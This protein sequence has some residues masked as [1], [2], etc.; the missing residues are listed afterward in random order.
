MCTM[1]MR[2]FGRSYFTPPAPEW[3]PQNFISGFIHPVQIYYNFL[4]K[5]S[6]RY[7]R[8]VASCVWIMTLSSSSGCATVIALLFLTV[9]AQSNIG[10]GDSICDGSGS[11]L[12]LGCQSPELLCEPP[13]VVPEP[14]ENTEDDA[15]HLASCYLQCLDKVS[16]HAVLVTTNICYKASRRPCKLC[17]PLHAAACSVLH[18]RDVRTT[19]IPPKWSQ[20]WHLLNCLD[21]QQ[22]HCFWL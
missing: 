2:G 10:S 1:R 15:T 22:A 8:W 18:M 7:N 5:N 4:S 21:I 6:L 12:G 17:W 13:D 20:A 19:I 3:L 16:A 11:G 9:H 14:P